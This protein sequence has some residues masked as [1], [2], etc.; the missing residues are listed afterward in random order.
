M[1]IA[2]NNTEKYNVCKY[3]NGLNFEQSLVYLAGSIVEGFGNRTSDIDVYV[4]CDDYK[5]TLK[6]GF[7]REFCIEREDFLIRN[8]IE[9][10]TRY[11]FEYY[12]WDKFESIIDKINNLNFRTDKHLAKLSDNDIDFL[13]RLKHGKAIVNIERFNGIKENINFHNLSKYLVFVYVEK[14]DG[15]LEDLEGALA[16]KDYGTS[17]ILTRLL[18]EHSILAYLAAYGETNPS[19]KWLYRK[20]KRYQENN[21]DKALL[22]KYMIFTGEPFVEDKIEKYSAKAIAFSQELI[23]KAQEILKL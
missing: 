6:N 3:L 2:T 8:V 15:F 20:L 19:R 7:D 14:Y 4:I 18:I 11:D 10:G 5:E 9:D 21:N 16:S 17:Y 1:G 22:N 13:H 23:V 12:T